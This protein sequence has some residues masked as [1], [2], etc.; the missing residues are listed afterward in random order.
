MGALDTV[1]STACRIPKSPWQTSHPESFCDCPLIGLA[2]ELFRIEPDDGGGRESR[3]PRSHIF[4][5][6]TAPWHSISDGLVQ[7]VGFPPESS[8]TTQYDQSERKPIKVDAICGSC[9]CDA[10]RFEADV[11]SSY[12]LNCHCS[13]CRRSRGAAHA[14]N[15]LTA[16]GF[17]WI[18]GEEELTS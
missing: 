8:F 7:H 11:Q 6:S 2:A 13:R 12:M 18:R 5:T 10:V 15:L 1:Y 17:N 3:Q 4:S 14:T 16:R 9:L